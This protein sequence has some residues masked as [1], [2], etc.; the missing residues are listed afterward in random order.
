MHGKLERITD[1]KG[2]AS[3]NMSDEDYLTDFE[4]FQQV[5]DKKGGLG[6]GDSERKYG[7]IGALIHQEPIGKGGEPGPSGRSVLAE[8]REP[9]ANMFDPK[10]AE[11]AAIASITP[12]KRPPTEQGPSRKGFSPG[13]DN[14]PLVR[15]TDDLEGNKDGVGMPAERDPP[16]APAE[17]AAVG[18][19]G[20]QEEDDDEPGTPRQDLTKAFEAEAGGEMEP[21][22]PGG[23]AAALA[24]EASLDILQ[25]PEASPVER[26]AAIALLEEMEAAVKS[27][28]TKRLQITTDEAARKAWQ[29]RVNE[30]RD[31]VE[32]RKSGLE[33]AGLGVFAKRDLKPGHRLEYTG[34]EFG[35]SSDVLNFIDELPEK[36]F[37]KVVTAYNY[38]KD[39]NRADPAKII[40]GDWQ[41]SKDL[42]GTPSAAPFVNEPQDASRANA[43]LDY[44]DEELFIVL[45][46]ELAAGGEVL[47]DYDL[48]QPK[49]V[50]GK[51]SSH[52]KLKSSPKKRVT[53]ADPEFQDFEEPP[54]VS[55]DPLES[56]R[57][58]DPKEQAAVWRGISD[59]ARKIRKA[60]AKAAK[61]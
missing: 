30:T 59:R 17:L 10:A 55:P 37:N 57:K 50:G 49:D 47:I 51:F 13:D 14:T 40:V 16:A 18:G 33:N 7:D 1:E 24:G 36:D 12:K 15:P 20:K 4:V 23:E 32:I 11:E 19:K 22:S 31:D 41:D 39:G 38:D 43:Q 48:V 5:F 56:W 44:F 61:K 29:E 8:T 34:K 53:F 54:P 25:D 52:K 58:M 45:T 2:I 6:G 26:S 60:K 46:E 28:K 9:E 42:E 3:W 27:T 21:L 35:Y